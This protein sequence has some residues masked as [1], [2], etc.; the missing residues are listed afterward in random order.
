M[1]FHTIRFN[2]LK[3]CFW[4]SG[5]VKNVFDAFP[6][7]Q[8]QVLKKLF[9]SPLEWLKTCFYAFRG[10]Q[11]QVPKKLIFHVWG[12]QKRVFKHLHILPDHQNQ[13][14]KKL[15]FDVWSGEKRVLMHKQTTK[16]KS[17]KKFFFHLW[18][19]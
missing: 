19:G 8:N 2:F 7:Y 9:F 4:T 5:V 11:N 3:I 10:Q 15:F 12:G 14:L 16:F 17:L 6:D 13:V 1:H 18:S